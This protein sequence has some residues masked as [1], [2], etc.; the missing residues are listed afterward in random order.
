MEGNRTPATRMCAGEDAMERETWIW[1]A[2]SLGE[3][4]W[5]GNVVTDWRLRVI[6]LEALCDDTQKD[7]N[8]LTRQ[9]EPRWQRQRVPWVPTATR[10]LTPGEWSRTRR[11]TTAW[12]ESR[13]RSQG[14][15]GV[16]VYIVRGQRCDHLGEI[17]EKV[18]GAYHLGVSAPTLTKDDTLG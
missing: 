6:R 16:C 7:G 14:S 10:A 3:Y 1:T 13:G 2:Q 8:V 12:W 4:Q 18:I 9:L 11:E 5:M 17:E 15:G